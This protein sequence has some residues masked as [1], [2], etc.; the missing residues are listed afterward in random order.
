MTGDDL[1]RVARTYLTRSRS[2]EAT[3]AGAELIEAA[4]KERPDLFKV[5]APV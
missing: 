1:Q 3:V 2:A 5:V 4:K